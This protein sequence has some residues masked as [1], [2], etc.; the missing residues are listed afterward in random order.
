MKSLDSPEFK[1]KGKLNFT[2]EGGKP[3]FVDQ[4]M[5]LKYMLRIF[6]EILY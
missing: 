4:Q 3:G 2:K 1:A 6:H 5:A